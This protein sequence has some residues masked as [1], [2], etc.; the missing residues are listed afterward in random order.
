MDRRSLLIAV[1]LSLLA[2]PH[3]TAAPHAAKILR[4]GTLGSTPIHPSVEEAFRQGLGQFGYIAGQNIIVEHR[5]AEGRPELL[6]ELA[7]DF[8][9]LQTDVIFARGPAAVMAV[10][11]VTS[12]IPIVAVD[13]ESDPVAMGFVAQLARPGGNI[14]GVFLDRPELSGKQLQLLKDVVPGISHVAV[15]GDP[16]LNAPQFR[17]VEVA[18]RALRV[19][20]QILEIHEAKDFD[21]ALEAA[22][23]APSQAV[24]VL[25]SPTVFNQRTRIGTI[26]AE[27]RLPTVS[28]FVE[29]AEAGGL[30]AYGPSVREAVRRCGVYVGRILQGAKPS[31]LPVERPEKFELVINR[32]T[33]NALGLT[34]PPS[35]LLRADQIIQ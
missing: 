10:K 3:A 29:F 28:L 21:S 2:T 24:I 5:H 4:I 33:A 26:A 11:K 30:M 25:S 27:K 31:E 32:K 22:R 1:S 19:Q 8:V 13:L 20:L 7:A 34:I 12:T 17:A 9:R 15:L 23:R 6:P 16:A 18:A 14:T 35:L